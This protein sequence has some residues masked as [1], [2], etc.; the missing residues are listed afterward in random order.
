MEVE[1]V[2]IPPIT[3]TVDSGGVCTYTIANGTASFKNKPKNAGATESPF[4]DIILRSLDV[5]YGWDDGA[6][7]PAASGGI[8]G[9]V[10]ANGSSTAQFAVVSADALTTG[11]R[12][13]HTATLGLTFRGVTVS[14]DDVSTTTGGTLQVNSCSTAPVGA[15]CTQNGACNVTSQ[16]SCVGSLGV[17]QG[18]NTSCLTVVCN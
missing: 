13:G 5:T 7:T 15:C 11:A 6:A 3:T 2:T 1:N 14:G 9:S 18:D 12:G 16:A 17:Y 4:N 8:A 10:P